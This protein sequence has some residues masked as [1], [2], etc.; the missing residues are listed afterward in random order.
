MG[1]GVGNW[2]ASTGSCTPGTAAGIPG[3]RGWGLGG[4]GGEEALSGRTTV[5]ENSAT[6]HRSKN[7]AIKTNRVQRGAGS[8]LGGVK[9][10]WTWVP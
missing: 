8:A 4:D 5:L 2:A 1:E 10:M 3:W 7:G 6:K 9:L